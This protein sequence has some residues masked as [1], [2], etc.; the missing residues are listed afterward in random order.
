MVEMLN[1]KF[2]KVVQQHKDVEGIVAQVL[3]QISWRIQQWK[4]FESRSTFVKVM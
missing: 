4:Y 2:R 3:L 1:F